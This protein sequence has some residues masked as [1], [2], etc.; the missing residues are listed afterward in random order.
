M[1]SN[2]RFGDGL[3]SKS[4]RVGPIRRFKTANL[5]SGPYRG[6]NLLNG[7]YR[8]SETAASAGSS[9]EGTL[10]SI[11]ELIGPIKSDGP[12]TAREM[13][14]AD[15][16]GPLLSAGPYTAQEEAPRGQQAAQGPLS[17]A[18]L[19]GP[20]QS[21]GPYTA[22]QMS[23]ADMAMDMVGPL[24]AD[25][26][27]VAQPQGSYVAQPVPLNGASGMA[28]IE[29]LREFGQMSAE[30]S[31]GPPE[32]AI[33]NYSINAKTGMAKIEMPQSALAE[34]MAQL[35]DLKTMKTAAMARV[36]QLRQQESS[37]SPLL[38]ALSQFAG[39]MASNDPTMPGWVRALGQTNLQ[40]GSQGIK[41]ER[42]AEEQRVLQLGQ[43]QA[44]MAQVL[45]QNQREERQLGLQEKS[46][47]AAQENKKAALVES[48]VKDVLGRYKDEVDKGRPVDPVL[49]ATELVEG[50][51]SK[52]R[53]IAAATQMTQ[54]SEANKRAIEESLA[55][56]IRDKKDLE[57]YKAGLDLD[58]SLTVEARKHAYKL[59]ELGFTRNAEIDKLS[60]AASMKEKNERKLP[61]KAR[62]TLIQI[63]ALDEK[64]DSLSERAKK[65][66]IA[67]GPV[68]GR[69]GSALEY[70]P[71]INQSEWAAE[72]R[73]LRSE[74]QRF[75]AQYVKA[76]QGGGNTISNKDIENAAK[77]LPNLNMTPEQ[78][79]ALANSIKEEGQ[80]QRD[81][82]RA[83]YEADWENKDKM[84]LGKPKTDE[85]ALA[86]A[87]KV[88]DVVTL[89]GV[90]YRKNGDDDY[91][92]VG[93]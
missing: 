42:M 63:N 45:L 49:I 86:K 12:Y 72:R 10:A 24:Q 60:A 92:E 41:R 28:P 85:I 26:P 29:K 15:L 9:L 48:R 78:F 62:E 16:I 59:A 74:L 55:A 81:A 20:L 27:Y 46:Y 89:K 65:Y 35:T 40:M 4:S 67:S 23:P 88:G 47:E 30:A 73:A 84:L 79:V 34:V 90:K 77:A 75:V 52:E 93:R 6:A 14:L 19:I 82:F 64:L 22:E 54:Q 38:D 11:A 91:V 50:G 69:L 25:G 39:N 13:A 71:G 83:S 1:S 68:G 51:L 36:A 31:K 37:G 87:A 7:T 57:D 53:A 18:D 5:L 61:A 70:L 3:P 32:A 2:Y 56:G 76:V 17:L 58:K 21:D 80:Y 66:S 43:S 44:Q 33:Q 8:P